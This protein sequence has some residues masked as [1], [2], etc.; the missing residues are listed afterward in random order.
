MEMRANLKEVR[1]PS[2]LVRV[3]VWVLIGALS[4]G[5]H[6]LID[7]PAGPPTRVIFEFLLWLTCFLPWAALAPVIFR[8]EQRYPLGSKDWPK[9]VALLAW[10]GI[11][12]AYIGAEIAFAL[13]V[14]VRV[15][16]RQPIDNLN[17][18]WRPSFLDLAVMTLSY[19]FTVAAGYVIRN[20]YELHE[21]E[22]EAAKLALEKA[23]LESSLHK[24]E[25]ETLRTRLNPH[26]LFNC[27]QNIAALTKEDAGA[28][29]RMLARLGDLLRTALRNDSGPEIPLASEIALTRTYVSVETV[30]FGDRLSVLFD[31]DPQTERALVPTFLLQPLVE[32]AILH[33]LQ[34]VQRIGVISVRSQIKGDDLLLVVTDNG[35]GLGTKTPEDLEMG[36][37]LDS[38]AKRL[39]KM[40]SDRHSLS[41]RPLPEGGTEVAILLP[42]HFQQPDDGVIGSEQSSLVDR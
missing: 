30:R 4:Y 28:A 12:V 42:L 39:A 40:Y 3:I 36:I 5:R 22:H 41:L 19:W 2:L 23:R 38:T 20:I 29:G 26:F 13:S 15:M 11:P 18:W 21:R 37:G 10:I 24:A 1:Y 6:Y 31:I 25:L 17:S 27:L 33:G 9:H 16:S 8:F 32:N 7:R 34:G 14:V 35:V